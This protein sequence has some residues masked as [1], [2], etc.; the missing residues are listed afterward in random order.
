MLSSDDIEMVNLGANML[1]KLP[2]KRW[3][4]I[5]KE[6]QEKNTWY[7]IINKNEITIYP[8]KQPTWGAGVSGT[9]NYTG[10]A[11]GVSTPTYVTGGWNGSTWGTSNTSGTITVT[12]NGQVIGRNGFNWSFE[13]EDRNVDLDERYQEEN[14]KRMKQGWTTK[15][16]KY[17]KTSSKNRRSKSVRPS[18]RRNAYAGR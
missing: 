7:F 18:A 8:I 1:R 3:A 15:T 6:C 11:P 5:M 4:K 16:N 17:G 2:R 12:K 10:W 9:F 14:R 13:Y